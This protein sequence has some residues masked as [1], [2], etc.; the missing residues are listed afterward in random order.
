VQLPL[1][2]GRFFERLFNEME[3]S[4]SGHV[5][6]S[7]TY[8]QPHTATNPNST[9]MDNYS[10]RGNVN[11]NTG[12]VGMSKLAW[13][14]LLWRY[15]SLGHR[16][17]SITRRWTLLHSGQVNVRK[18]WP[19]VLGSIA[20]NLIGEPQAVH[21]GPW[22]CVSSMVGSPQFGARSSPANHPT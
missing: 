11:P 19:N 2:W 7:A 14:S 21:C 16:A 18:S 20:V 9:Q 10:T 6:S 4:V 5:T 17:L 13:R 12:V 1:R 3:I 15:P 22:F 8:V